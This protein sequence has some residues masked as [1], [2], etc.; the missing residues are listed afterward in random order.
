MPSFPVISGY[1]FFHHLPCGVQVR[2]CP[3][4]PKLIF[5]DAAYT[6]VNRILIRVILIRCTQYHTFANG[7]FRVVRAA[8]LYAPVAVVYDCFPAMDIVA[9]SCIFRTKLSHYSGES[10]PLKNAIFISLK[11]DKKRF[12]PD[13]LSHLKIGS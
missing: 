7:E 3:Y 10:E 8:V 12:I 5:K 11:L 13:K 4:K 9:Q 1:R 6:L 2:Q